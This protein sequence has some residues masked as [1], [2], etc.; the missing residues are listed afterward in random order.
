[1]E[2]VL[3][4]FVRLEAA[5]AELRQPKVV[6][7]TFNAH[8]LDTTLSPLYAVNRNYST[9]SGFNL[10]FPEDRTF[11]AGETYKID[12]G[13]AGAMRDGTGMRRGYFLLPRSSIHHTPLSMTNGLGLV[14]ACY[15]GAL[16]VG[17]R[18]HD[19]YRDK[20]GSLHRITEYKVYKGTS[21]FQVAAATL[22]PFQTVFVTQ[23][24]AT[25]RGSGGFGSTNA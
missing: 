19:T 4:N 24:D 21:L 17:I 25:D 10:I 22:E 8:L 16:Q 9:D 20:E 3:N 14:D 5:V 2:T 11:L 1:M 18:V 12:L 15:N 7:P 13:I 23:L 6:T